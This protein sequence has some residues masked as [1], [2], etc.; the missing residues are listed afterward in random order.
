MRR[1]LS[2]LPAVVAVAGLSSGLTDSFAAA[3]APKVLVIGLDGTRFDK[4]MAAVDAPRVATRFR[5]R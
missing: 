4:L 3:E 2:L 1:T 5:P